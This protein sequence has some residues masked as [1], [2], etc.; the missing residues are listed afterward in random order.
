[1]TSKQERTSA[2]APPAKM[3]VDETTSSTSGI[4]ALTRVVTKATEDYGHE[5]SFASEMLK[6]AIK[7]FDQT[8]ITL[9][10]GSIALSV[11]YVHSAKELRVALAA[12]WVSFAIALI[13]TLVSFKLVQVPLAYEVDRLV[14]ATRRSEDGLGQAAIGDIEAASQAFS[15]TAEELWLERRVK[16]WQRVLL[17]LNIVGIAAFVIGMVLL[18]VVAWH[19]DTSFGK[20]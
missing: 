20:A 14:R 10:A 3:S 5:R 8:L 12:S 7:S 6:D 9:A 13:L 17:L 19:P 11:T 2:A 4:E 1:M 16:V 18:F 15:P